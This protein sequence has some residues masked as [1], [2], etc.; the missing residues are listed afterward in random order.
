MLMP[1]DW[2][3]TL[4]TL[5]PQFQAL[6]AR[7]IGLHHIMVEAADNERTKLAGPPWFEGFPSG[8]R[9][10]DG[11]PAYSKWD[12]S[13]SRSLPCVS[14]SFREAGANETFK[15]DQS[16]RLIRDRSGVVRAVFV[17]MKIRQGF[18]CGQPSDEIAGFESLADAAAIALA[19]S[20]DLN[21]HVFAT[22]LIDI[23]R[24]PRAGVRYVFGE[25]PSVP[26]RFIS[27]GW[28][29]GVLQFENGVL[30]DAPIGESRPDK[31][32]WMLLLHRLGWRRIEGCGLR[33]DRFSWLGN[34]EVAIE[35]L[36]DDRLCPPEF[37][38]ERSFYSTLGTKDAPLDVSLASAF[39]IRLLLA[40]L[41]PRDSTPH[42]DLASPTDYS[43]EEWKSRALPRI[44]PVTKD[45][46]Q[47]LCRPRV[48][49]L[50][51][52]EVERQAVLKSIR[53]PRGKQSVLQVFD[54]RNTCFIGRLGVTDE[55]VLNQ[56]GA[57]DAIP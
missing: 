17:P 23:F 3:D 4:E 32:H 52:T 6:A 19:G 54:D 53:P 45:E 34:S 49:I 20:N 9:I 51:A 35:M 16:D 8:F 27:Q 36:L 46:S 5:L 39:A 24:E 56:P 47:K 15:D 26:N 31:G 41:S 28:Q 30:I 50:V 40:D 44:Q 43:R 33:A 1:L 25:V 13:A 42:D 21:K 10:I 7:S 11:K 22:E 29:A 37:F 12:A 38:R 55:H 18:F 57:L 48:G 14:P 2:R